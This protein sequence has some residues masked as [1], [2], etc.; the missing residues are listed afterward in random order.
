M[1]QG[2]RIWITRAPSFPRKNVTL[3]K[4]GAGIQ[5]PDPTVT[6][7]DRPVCDPWTPAPFCNGVGSL[8]E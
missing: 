6:L 7:T 1:L 2:Y 8:L 3:A 5:G 4:A